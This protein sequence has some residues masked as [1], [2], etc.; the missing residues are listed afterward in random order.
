MLAIPPS[1]LPEVLPCAAEF[2]LLRRDVL[3]REIPILAMAGDQQAA[4]FGQ[5]CFERGDAKN[6]YGT[7]CFLLMNTGDTP[8]LSQNRLL[9][10]IA[11]D[12]GAGPV[13]ALEGSV[14]MAGATIQWLRDELGLIRTSAESEELARSVED[15]GGVYLVPAFTGLGAPWWDMDARG[16]LVGLTRGCG[17]AHIVRAALE[18]IALQS[19]DVLTAM[20]SDSGTVIRRLK[21]DGGASA[22][23]FLMQFQADLLGKEVIRPTCA[24]TTALG[25]A[26]LAALACGQFTDT[27]DIA[28]RWKAGAEYT[29]CTDREAQKTKLTGWHRAIAR[30]Q[31]W[32]QA[33]YEG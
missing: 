28:R 9:T 27:C 7:G 10:T 20:E 12:I 5:A 22:N 30:A 32:E 19:Y 13:Y 11:W 33:K 2:G 17:R 18:A 3:G 24:E 15:T 21:V 4:L 6:T 14:F 31:G 8:V 16:I 29:P 25:A 26:Y 23:G 1:I